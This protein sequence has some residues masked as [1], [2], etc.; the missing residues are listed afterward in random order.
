M[1]WKAGR[2]DLDCSKTLVMGVVNLTPD[3]FSDGGRYGTPEQAVRH[4][5][6][7]VDQGADIVDL[8]AESTRPGAAEVS[9]ADELDRVLPVLEALR[10]DCG[11]PISVDTT[12]PGVAARCLD[13]GADVIN[14]VSGLESSGPQMAE[15]V[16]G[17]GAGLVLMHRRGCPRTMQGLAHYQNV[18]EEVL[19][20]LEQ[21]IRKALDAGIER[22]RLA[23][24]PG[25]GFS[26]NAQQSVEIIRHLE[27]FLRLELP[28]VLGH[29]RKSFIGA[30]TGKETGS[31]E[32]GTAAVSAYAVLKGIHIL[33]VH[34]AEHTRDVI[35]VVEKL[36]GE[37]TYVGTF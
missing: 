4:A 20:G 34:D 19:A 28:V 3:S 24:D 2:F 5:L 15:T 30:L 16:R 1:I 32:F 9:E 17:Y 22:E 23:V 10:K 29:S 8:G 27:A 37:E 35:C 25:I 14:D 12:K 18:V 11:V 21:S 36:R 31:R 26:K 13:L 6:S 33:R 7:L